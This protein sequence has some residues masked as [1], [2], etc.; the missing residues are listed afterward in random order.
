M[1][2]AKAKPVL[3]VALTAP[4]LRA[5]LAAALGWPLEDTQG[6]SL[7][8]LRDLV[9]PVSPKLAHEIDCAIAGPGYIRRG[10]R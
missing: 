1:S 4:D 7:L 5:R 9:R 3:R 6:F 2:A 8:A 10:A